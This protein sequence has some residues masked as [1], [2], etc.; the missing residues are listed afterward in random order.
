M[1]LKQNDTLLEEIYEQRAVWLADYNMTEN[2]VLMDD[3]G[4]FIISV[5]EQGNPGDDYQFDTKYIYLPSNLLI[6]I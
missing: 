1:S 5:T 4:E 2:D 3:N 6:Q